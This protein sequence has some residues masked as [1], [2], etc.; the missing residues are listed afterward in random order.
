[1]PVHTDKIRLSRWQLFTDGASKGNPGPAGAGWVLI[2]DQ[3]SDSVKEGKYLGPATNN[4]AE[5]Q[6]L[7]LGLQRA[8]SRGVQEIRIHMDSELLVRQL[9]GHY[10]VK[11][12]RLGLLFHQ[13]QDLLLKFSKYDIIHIPREQ[14][15]D[16][17][18]MANEA[19][20]RKVT[21]DV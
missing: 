1:M 6:A 3:N 4:E 16:A 21:S 7:I 18:R 17:D 10:R 13:V 8:L 11:N 5:Y 9:N 12:P 19:I 15:R 14:N 20:K 2:N